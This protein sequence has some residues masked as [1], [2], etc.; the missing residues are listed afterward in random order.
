M[1]LRNLSRI[2]LPSERGYITLGAG[3]TPAQVEEVRR[4]IEAVRRPFIVMGSES[5]MRYTSS[6]SC[7]YCGGS[8]FSLRMKCE[9]CGAPY[10]KAD[11][12][13]AALSSRIN[14]DRTKPPPP[15]PRW[16]NPGGYI[17]G[18]NV[19]EIEREF[20]ELSGKGGLRALIRRVWLTFYYGS[21]H[22]WS[23]DER[24]QIEDHF[25]SIA[26]PR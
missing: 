12:L 6:P 2:S 19:W 9:G 25:R 7:E 17:N 23:P 13:T 1:S 14:L 21:I 26:G 8:A 3:V 5:D 4:Q 10:S 22:V 15:P 16:L 20:N 18:K 24:A 11:V